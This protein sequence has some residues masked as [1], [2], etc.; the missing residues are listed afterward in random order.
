MAVG[1]S[2]R[3]WGTLGMAWRFRV[4]PRFIPT[5]VGNASGTDCRKRRSPVHPHARGERKCNRHTM[6]RYEVHPHARGERFAGT[7][8]LV[9]RSGSSPRTWGTRLRRARSGIRS[10]F[11]PTHVGNATVSHCL[12]SMRAVH[13]HARGER[14][15]LHYLKKDKDGSSP[16]TWGTPRTGKPVD[17][18][19]RFIPT[20]VGNAQISRADA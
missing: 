3:T 14:Y 15:L 11:I 10:R 17:I 4:P 16:R 20:H 19:A 18:A 7:I 12:I 8:C 13:P 1:S 5:H 2:P 6:H 9:R